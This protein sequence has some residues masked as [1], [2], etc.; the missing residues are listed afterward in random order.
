MDY[1][2]NWDK[3]KERL[4]AFWEREIIDRCCVSI[5]SPK[6]GVGYTLE[7]FPENAADRVNFWTDGEWVLKR[8]K[9]KF[10]STYFAG[11]ATPQ[12]LVN[13]GATGHAGYFKNVRYQFEDGTVW[14]YP[15]INDWNK[16]PL[17]FEP[18]GFLYSKTIQLA[19]YL[20]NESKGSF[21]VSMPDTAGNMDALAHIRGS[22]NLLMDLFDAEDHVRR[23]LNQIQDVWLKVN[24]EVYDITSENNEGG[25]CITWLGTWAPGK[26]AQ[27]QCDLSAMISPDTY[28]RFILPE[29]KAQCEW[30]DYPLYH[31]D[32]IEQIRHLDTILSLSGLKAIQWTCVEG[33]PSPLHFIPVLKRIQEAGKSLLIWIKP[34]ELTQI[35]EQLSSKG[36]YLLL[37]ADSEKDADNLVRVVEKLSHE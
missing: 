5:F 29:L 25:S 14:F 36:L 27:M 20:T 24:Q 23:A 8:N 32:G 37:N 18:K 16:D 2:E 9:A 10:E 22:E 28:N 21:F 17:V 30:M 13:L 35:M 1:R 34:E 15:F 19:Q 33:Q 26:H 4:K 3:S 11:E 12:I 7:T 6:D 31:L